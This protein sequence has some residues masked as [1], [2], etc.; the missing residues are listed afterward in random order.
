MWE[1]E[2]AIQ[3]GNE[4]TITLEKP[5]K[6]D[7]GK[8][9]VETKALTWGYD[10]SM[11]TVAKFKKMVKQETKYTLDHLNKQETETDVT[12]ELKI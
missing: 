8:D 6:D 2:K 9:Q 7:E 1:Y 12:T 3:K 5:Y 10:K 11:G 4:I